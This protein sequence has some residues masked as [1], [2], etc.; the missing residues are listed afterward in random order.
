MD[1]DTISKQIFENEIQNP[2]MDIRSKPGTKVIF[3]YPE[4][5]SNSDIKWANGVLVV[6]ETYTVEN[7]QIEQ[8]ISLVDFKEFPEWQFNTVHFANKIQ[9]EK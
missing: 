3:K 8:S 4:N 7:I 1:W 9:G 6:G 5:G 2:T